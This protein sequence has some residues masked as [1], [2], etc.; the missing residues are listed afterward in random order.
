MKELKT[1]ELNEFTKTGNVAIDFWADWCGP[2]KMLGPI[3]EELSQEITTVN[4]AKADM[5]E[6]GE[7]AMT[8]G[9]RGVPT[10][11]LFKDGQEISRIVGFQQ[12]EQLK[13]QIQEAFN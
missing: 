11:I 1:N 5:D 4:F 8:L 13:T 3:F 12:K 7:E 2:C 6:I 9:V 10:I